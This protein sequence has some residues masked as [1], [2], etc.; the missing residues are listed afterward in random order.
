MGINPNFKGNQRL[1]PIHIHEFNNLRQLCSTCYPDGKID[2]TTWYFNYPSRGGKT[3]H[4]FNAM[5]SNGPRRSENS[6]IE[7]EFKVKQ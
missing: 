3:F 4:T 7:V 6:F 2:R 1:I 5:F